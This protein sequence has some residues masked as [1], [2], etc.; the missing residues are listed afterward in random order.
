MQMVPTRAALM[1]LLLAIGLAGCTCGGPGT[2]LS[3]VSFTCNPPKLPFGGGSV[4][5]SWNVDG[6]IS[7]SIDQGVGVVNPTNAGSISVMVTAATTFTLTA[8]GTTET[9]TATCPVTV[10]GPG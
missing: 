5:L 1:A 7:L 8:T 6:A 2:P 10:E 4:M 9:K 3:I